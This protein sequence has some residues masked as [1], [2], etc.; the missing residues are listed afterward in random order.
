MAPVRIDTRGLKC[1][2]PV[3]RVARAAREGAACM[4]V[5]T[6]DPIAP[7]EIAALADA[8]GWRMA[9]EADGLHLWTFPER[10]E[11]AA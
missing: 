10:A 11:P 8:R 6:D 4:V 1:P 3:L 5:L 7:G 2:W 9:K